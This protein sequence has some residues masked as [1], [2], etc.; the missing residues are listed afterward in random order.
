MNINELIKS[1]LQEIPSNVQQVNPKNGFSIPKL[2]LPAFGGSLTGTT[3]LNKTPS[4]LELSLQK[5]RDAGSGKSSSG[6]SIQITSNN[7]QMTKKFEELV[8]NPET[9]S[10][11]LTTALNAEDAVKPSPSRKSLKSKEVP[12]A[13][14]E[15]NPPM[16]IEFC[17]PNVSRFRFNKFCCEPSTFGK[18]TCIRYRRYSPKRINIDHSFHPKHSISRFTFTTKSPDDIVISKNSKI[19]P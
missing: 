13:I 12:A 3:S 6:N 5:I 7:E 8:I 4:A 1:R 14:V 10:I 16:V 11:D 17:D 19:K 2:N 9:K 18:I 15:K